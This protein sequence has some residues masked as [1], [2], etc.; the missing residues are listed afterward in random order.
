[1][2][3]AYKCPTKDIPRQEAQATKP[4]KKVSKNVASEL[5]TGMTREGW[6][7]RQKAA[8]AGCTIYYASEL[9]SRDAIWGYAP[10][11]DAF[12]A[13][14]ANHLDRFPSE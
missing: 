12:L 14:K 3:Q 7:W 6:E 11:E 13:A 8:Q 4:K 10:D 2:S 9:N 1:M 5:A